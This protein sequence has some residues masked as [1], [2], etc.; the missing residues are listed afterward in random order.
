MLV[1]D[2]KPDVA[3]HLAPTPSPAL[4]HESVHTPPPPSLSLRPD[5][6][7]ER[8]RQLKAAFDAEYDEG[9]GAGHLEELRREASRQAEV[10]RAELEAMSESA[11]LQF[12]GFHPGTYVRVEVK[13]QNRE[14]RSGEGKS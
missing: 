10:N 12:E 2:C 6:Q 1:F 4:H 8:K 5:K 11:R 3:W 14:Q 9:E 13:G 7:L